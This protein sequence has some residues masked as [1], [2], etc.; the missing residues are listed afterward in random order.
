[1][2]NCGS[3]TQS[4]ASKRDRLIDAALRLFYEHGIE[5]TTIADIAAAA[6]VPPGNVYYYFKTKEDIVDAVVSARVTEIEA[7]LA[8]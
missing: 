1:M 7:T 2:K 3:H 5:R 4:N 6:N 8:A